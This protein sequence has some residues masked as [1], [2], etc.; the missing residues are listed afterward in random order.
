M[1]KVLNEFILAFQ[2]ILDYSASLSKSS[3]IILL[4]LK[5][6]NISL[7]TTSLF[8]SLAN[9]KQEI[10]SIV[11]IPMIYYLEESPWISTYWQYSDYI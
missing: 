8:F 6:D 11:I 3:N 10:W 7:S 4:V 2:I 5:S 9:F 1:F